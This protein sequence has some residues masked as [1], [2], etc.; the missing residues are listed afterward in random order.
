VPNPQLLLIRHAEAHWTRDETGGLSENGR[1]EA[2]RLAEIFANL[3]CDAI[4]S[5]PFCRARQTVAPLALRLGLPV[6]E[7]PDLRERHLG[8]G[9]F[10]DFRAAVRATWDD[11]SFS[12]PG[13]ESNAQAQRRM[14][15]AH[16]RLLAW[17]PGGR[18]LVSTHGNVLG[19]LLRHYDPSV[20]F[21]FW[22]GLSRPD[23][24]RLRIHS[25]GSGTFERAWD[26]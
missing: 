16:E 12:H 21:D 9:P 4:Y 24:Y 18:I 15:A 17:H 11:F 2:E 19:L 23:V 7:L 6:H 22:D 1:Q 14:V 13:G 10:Q 20:G 3:Q 8:T 26:G 25:S 5:S